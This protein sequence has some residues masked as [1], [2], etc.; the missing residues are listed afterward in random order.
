MAPLG[1]ECL[2]IQQHLTFLFQVILKKSVMA[3]KDELISGKN[4]KMYQR[5]VRILSLKTSFDQF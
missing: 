1:N 5:P 2:Q 4:L 3:D